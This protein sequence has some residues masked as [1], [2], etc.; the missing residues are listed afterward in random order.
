MHWAHRQQGK[1]LVP[2]GHE[3]LH[4]QPMPVLNT[5]IA[6][7][8]IQGIPVIEAG[9]RTQVITGNARYGYKYRNAIWF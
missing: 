5:C 1:E 4:V 2:T 9:S 6:S 3:I 8:V 7:K